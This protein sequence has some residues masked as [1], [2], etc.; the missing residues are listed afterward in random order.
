MLEQCVPQLSKNG[1]NGKRK[2]DKR[3]YLCLF[4]Y[5]NA[6]SQ[7]LYKYVYGASAYQPTRQQNHI[8][9]ILLAAQGSQIRPKKC[10][11]DGKK[12]PH[13]IICGSIFCRQNCDET[14]KTNSW[15]AFVIGSLQLLIY[16]L[17]TFF[18]P[19]YTIAKFYFPLIVRLFFASG[20]AIFICPVF[21]RY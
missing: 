1:T 6:L 16:L 18:P 13:W 11:G 19:L 9:M 8:Y 5:I 21:L 14:R 4:V 17:A 15:S 3:L 12:E 20:F 2:R 7:W 10:P